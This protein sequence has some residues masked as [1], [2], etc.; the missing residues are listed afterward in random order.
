MF[1]AQDAEG[2]LH[3]KALKELQHLAVAGDH[4]D[5]QKLQTLD[6]FFS[7]ISTLRSASG[8]ASGPPLDQAVHPSEQPQPPRLSNKKRKKKRKQAQEETSLAWQQQQDGHVIDTIAPEDKAGSVNRVSIKVIPDCLLPPM[9]TASAG[10]SSEERA[11]PISETYEPIRVYLYASRAA[12]VHPNS[13]HS[14][15]VHACASCSSHVEAANSCGLAFL[16]P[17]PDALLTEPTTFGLRGSNMSVQLEFLGE[18]YAS[19]GEM[20]AMQTFHRSILCWETDGKLDISDSSQMSDSMKF[21]WPL[22]AAEWAKSSSNAWYILFPLMHS[23]DAAEVISGTSG[24]F[25]RNSVLAKRL[26]AERQ[27]ILSSSDVWLRHLLTCAD[28]ASTLVDNL[29]RHQYR[30]DKVTDDSLSAVTVGGGGSNQKLSSKKTYPMMYSHTRED[31]VGQLFSRDK[32]YI[33]LGAEDTQETGI[34]GPVVTFDDVMREGKHLEVHE[35]GQTKSEE[36]TRSAGVTYLEYFLSKGRMSVEEADALRKKSGKPT[37]ECE[38]RC[39][40]F[41]LHGSSGSCLLHACL[42]PQDTG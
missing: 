38:A 25:S 26:D 6:A 3:V 39:A 14:A 29:F 28:E 12:V 33:Y 10:L 42:Y 1:Y 23:V 40:L 19:A 9:A 21:D 11:T 36:D 32:D 4:Y 24:L 8:H 2:D 15:F 20:L 35:V 41:Y 5:Q 31:L 30:Q 18:K 27:S 7:A 13:T 37:S 17:L 22:S 34:N 16:Q